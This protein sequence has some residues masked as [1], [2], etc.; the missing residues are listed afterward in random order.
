MT[1]S[2]RS[3]S[4]VSSIKIRHFKSLKECD[5]SLGRVNV[6]IGPNGAGKSNLLEAIGVL[7]AA[8]GG[9]VNDESLFRRGVRPGVPALY[10]SS[11]KGGRLPSGIELGAS[12]GAARTLISLRNPVRPGST[13]WTYF[14]EGLYEGNALIAGRSQRSKSPINPESGRIALAMADV[15][16]QT[17]SSLLV[18]ALNRYAIYTPTTAVLRG[19]V[20]EPVR[21]P[22]GLSGGRLAEAFQELLLLTRR[23]ERGD[24]FK[25]IPWA[26][27]IGVRPAGEV[28]V[29]PSVPTPQQVL[30]F[31]DKYMAEGRNKLSA[32]DAS[33]GAL[34]VLFSLVAAL[35]P[36]MPPLFSIDN[37][38]HGIHPVLG[39]ALLDQLSEWVLLKSDRQVLLTLQNPAMLDG[40]PIDNPEVKLF[41][42]NRTSAGLTDIHPLVVTP[43]L[44][45][46]AKT[47]WTLSRMW[48]A[49]HLGGV[50][51]V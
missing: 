15:A 48:V 22:V 43:K 50:P 8:L 20:Q 28:P 14:S 10:K 39:M 12:L 21:P 44:L 23:E 3:K 30:H 47:G 40:L 33:E 1:E 16:P 45:E 25:F 34:F 29:S 7:G 42:V 6:F 38:D 26:Q 32:Y 9:K 4:Y 37:F 19:I 13:A 35:H 41:V 2:V 5:L 17:E 27:K 49:G 24:Y 46:M 11:F 18:D 36:H 51:D 31:E